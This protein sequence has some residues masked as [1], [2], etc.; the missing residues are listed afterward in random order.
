MRRVLPAVLAL[1][2]AAAAAACPFCSAP[3]LT[4]TEQLAQ[5]QVA[6]IAEWRDAVRGDGQTVA[7]TTLR[8]RDVL[9]PNPPPGVAAGQTVRLPSYRAAEP[10]GLFLLLANDAETATATFEPKTFG[11]DAA[12]LA[13]VIPRKDGELVWSSPIEVSPDA[14]DYIASLPP[15]SQPPSERLVFFMKYLEHP[16]DTVGNDAYSEFASAPYDVIRPLAGKMP[17]ENLRKWVASPDTPPT[18][19][20]LYGLMLGLSGEASDLPLME[21]KITETTEEFRLGID[22]VMGGYILLA[23]EPGLKLI[24]DTKLKDKSVLFSET[25]AA[26]QA[27]RFLWSDDADVIPKERLRQAMRILLGRPEVADL[28]IAD[29]ARWADWSVMDEVRGLYEAEGYDTGSVKRAII[30]YFMT[31]T[32]V[33]TDPPPPELKAKA[34]EILAALKEQ[35]P[36]TYKAAERFFFLNG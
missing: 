30:R 15:R 1:L 17:V 6:V 9:T 22:G 4:L 3:S 18:R 35:D 33:K 14:A 26:M 2:V 31:A 21:R 23:G 24:E 10:G 7:A 8:I 12:S 13:D 5:S 16:D 34:A 25:Y 36:K 29:L 28:V 20:G 32:Q 27:L 11:E 19:L